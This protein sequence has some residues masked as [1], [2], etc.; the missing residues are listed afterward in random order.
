MPHISVQIPAALAKNLEKVVASEKRK[1]RSYIKHALEKF[2]EE[3]LE[4]IEDY[5]DG[6]RAREEFIKSGRQA[7]SWEEVFKK[8][9]VPQKNK[10]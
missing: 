9:R 2:L 1:T 3:N 4:D 8:A 6:M 5:I 7:I 10:N